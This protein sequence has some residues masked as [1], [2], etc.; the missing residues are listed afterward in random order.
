[1]T[2]TFSGMQQQPQQQHHN[3]GTGPSIR[4]THTYP[5]N[6]N[7]LDPLQQSC[8]VAIGENSHSCNT[9][10]GYMKRHQ[11]PPK[12]R[13]YHVEY[14]THSVM[15]N[16]VKTWFSGT[17]IMSKAFV[18]TENTL[19]NGTGA[20]AVGMENAF[21]ASYKWEKDK[22]IFTQLVLR[23][24]RHFPTTVASASQNLSQ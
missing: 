1:M 10:Q 4:G 7:V 20:Y 9:A 15:S 22:P 3:H 18:F 23:H 8:C 21:L 19:D 14:T 6:A 12:R 13:Q 24:L 2:P 16:I 17:A 11:L 5:L